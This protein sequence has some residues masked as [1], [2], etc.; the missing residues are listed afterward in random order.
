MGSRDV[1]L[2]IVLTYPVKWNAYSI[3][4]DYVQNFYDAVQPDEWKEAFRYSYDGEERRLIMEVDRNG[5]SYEWLMHIG[6]SSK[7]N[8]EEPHAGYFGEGFKIASLCAIRDFRWGIKMLSRDWEVTVETMVQELDGQMISVLAYHI[9]DGKPEME[10]SRLEISN[11]DEE[12]YRIF[13]VV[14]RS[15][16]YPENELFGKEIWSCE[17]AAIYERSQVPIDAD[18]PWTI[19]L[20]HTG[21]VFCAY[22]MRGTIPFELVICLHRHKN[23]DRDR[24]NLDAKQVENVLDVIADI[25]PCSVAVVLLEKMSLYWNRQ[26]ENK[27]NRRWSTVIFDLIRNIARSEEATELFRS[28]NPHLLCIC[29]PKTMKEKNR[30]RQAKA[31]HALYMPDYRLVRQSFTYLKYDILED[32]CEWNNGFMVDDRAASEQESTRYHVLEKLIRETFGGLFAFGSSWPELS[33]ITNPEAIYKGAACLMKKKSQVKNVYGMKIQYDLEKVHMKEQLFRLDS[34]EEA[35]STYVHE[36]CHVFG[37]D[38]SPQFTSA[39]SV[40]MEILMRNPRRIEQAQ[41]DWRK[42]I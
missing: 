31:W 26:W 41:R 29:I 12:I 13:P 15:F 16:Y 17:R 24:D 6:A 22:Q 39:L 7:T 5:F 27:K 3:L 2:N 19:G 36:L 35:L 38:A 34:F 11:L 32:V 30:R 25:I 33:V 18:L 9:E 23:D 4:R 10:G 37:G 8:S 1:S 20:G 14:L 40:S 28:R 42:K 21:A